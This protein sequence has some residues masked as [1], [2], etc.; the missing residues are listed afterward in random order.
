[1]KYSGFV[2]ASH[3]FS[4]FACVLVAVGGGLQICGLPGTGARN[5]GATCC[6][7][8]TKQIHYVWLLKIDRMHI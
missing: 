8:V 3:R 7:A 1:M 5:S 2:F 4:T 6:S